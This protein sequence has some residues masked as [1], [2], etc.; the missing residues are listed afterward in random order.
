MSLDKKRFLKSLNTLIKVEDSNVQGLQKQ[1]AEITEE[2]TLLDDQINS[3]DSAVEKERTFIASA[4]FVHN[5]FAIFKACMDA[6]KK[7]ILQK[8][9]VLDAQWLKIHNQLMT[10]VHSQKAYES[11][12]SKTKI[13][14]QDALEKD[15]QNLLDDLMQ[16][17]YIQKIREK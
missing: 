2:L 12:Q 16:I 11:I 17:R 3:I 5:N 13:A 4:K 6:K 14:Q 9:E 15:E 1:I 7:I 10:H 8:K